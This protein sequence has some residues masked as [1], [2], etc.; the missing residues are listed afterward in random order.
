MAEDP[1]APDELAADGGEVP[2]GVGPP[3]L[4]ELAATEDLDAD[5]D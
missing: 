5:G 2:D 3:T 1:C 4:D